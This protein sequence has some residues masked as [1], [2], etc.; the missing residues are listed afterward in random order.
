MHGPAT[1]AQCGCIPEHAEHECPGA[2]A[3]DCAGRTI[4]VF[5]YTFRT[6]VLAPGDRAWHNCRGGLMT[7]L[8]SAKPAGT[9]TWID[10]MSPSAEAARAFY[11]SVFG[12]HYDINPAFGGYTTAR[13]GDRNTAGVVGDQPDGPPPSAAWSLYFATNAIDVDVARAV[14]LGAKLQHPAMSVGDFGSMATL[15]DPTGAPFSLWQAGSHVGFQVTGEPGSPAWFELYSPDVKKSRDFYAELL[16]ATA[17]PMPG[18][19]EY[20]TLKHGVQQLAGVMQIDPAW[21]AMSAQWVVYFVVANA[22]ETV[23]TV[24][25][26]GG[27]VFGPIDDSPFGRLAA[28]AD[29][30]GANFKIVQLP[31]N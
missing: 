14:R 19:L 15:E 4:I 11:K 20:Y 7:S 2:S 27:K 13:L 24:L 6:F 1:Q 16:G 22:D 8:L 31:A 25:A 28:L 18:G 21:G 17:E 5:T 23:A 3:A 12:W 29:P 9:P 30:A 10:I 26:N